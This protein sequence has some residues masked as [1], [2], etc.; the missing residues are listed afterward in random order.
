MFLNAFTTNFLKYAF[1]TFCLFAAG[2]NG[3]NLILNEI[4]ADAPDAATQF[5]CQYVEL[6][7]TPGATVPAGRYFVSINGAS[8]SF[9]DVSF[10]VS[11]GGRTVGTNGTITIINDIKG[12]CPNRT[13]PAGT[14]L[15]A[16]QD[17][18]GLGLLDG[19]ARTFAIISAATAPS[20]G[21]DLDT[22]NDRAIDPANGVSV[23]DGFGF[24]TN[25]TFQTTYAPNLFDAATQ[26]A[27]GTILLPDAATRFSNDTTPLSGA[28]WYF[29][30]LASSPAE[31]TQYS[32]SP[33]SA[34]FPAGGALTPGLPNVPA[35]AAPE[36]ATVDFDGDG[37]TD[38]SV[39]R[40][41]GGLLNWFTAING[42]TET[43]FVQWGLP[44]DVPVPED[45]DGDGKDDL[46]VWRAG[47]PFEAGFYIL[48]SSN[49]TFKLETFGQTGDN[50]GL[51][52]DW[53]GDGKADPAVYRDD[54]APG[55]SFFYYRAS[56]DN[57]NGDITYV[58]WGAAGDKPV[59]GDF[60]GDGKIDAAVFRGSNSVW[61]IRQS[62]NLQI[63]YDYFGVS[64]DRFV[65]ADYDG[66]DKTDLAI[67]R[68]GV[69]WIKQSSDNAVSVQNWGLA[70]DVPIPGDY[71]GDG[72]SDTAV[73]RDGTLY[74]APTGGGNAIITNWGLTG[75]FPVANIYTE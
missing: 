20:A 41:V 52:G 23:I 4:E 53:D 11:L 38:F 33:Q 65:A 67:F 28:A 45:F 8:G 6:R 19:G 26:G 62:S 55:Q 50:P 48:Q 54:A 34:N 64:S 42:T 25:L 61:Y 46:A 73:W 66:D 44:G 3:Q 22:N 14:T 63:R 47:N 16:V 17:F 71:N 29:G 32:G 35:L 9:G 49:N 31:T 2:A 75:D 21:D 39:T 58:P 59:R 57:P 18:D 70:T 1:L 56:N 27:P 13:F 72:R 68:G 30:E 60:D 5:S 69:W 15:V 12:T 43:R 7:G 74:I 24:T 36:K 37:R 40:N 10:I 51:V